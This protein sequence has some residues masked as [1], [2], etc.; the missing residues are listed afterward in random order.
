MKKLSQRGLAALGTCLLISAVG[1][2]L[3]H[4]KA[5]GGTARRLGVPARNTT[6]EKVFLNEQLR[7]T[8]GHTPILLRLAQIERKEGDLA[9]ARRL[10]EEAVAAN[11]GQVDLRL[12][13]GLVCSEMG[14]VVAAEEQNR[15]VLRLMPGQPDALY[16]LGAIAANR[17]DTRQARQY[18]MSA[19][20][21][22]RSNDAAVKALEGIQRLQAAR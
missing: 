20:A 15:E 17:G 14:D 10:L 16:N 8:P 11:G 1:W 13:L 9:A 22:G 6:H 21:S 7:R 18:W 5:S 4:K 2:L 3:L 12:E 19:V